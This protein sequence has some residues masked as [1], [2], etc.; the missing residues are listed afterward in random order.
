VVGSDGRGTGFGN[1][2]IGIIQGPDQVNTDLAII[3]R[4]RVA[5]PGDR[6]NIE[7]RA[8]FFNL[9]NHPQFNDPGTGFGTA[10]FGQVLSMAVSPRII[11]FALKF[12]F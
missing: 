7:F 10:A 6:A 11:Q 8:E 12:N 9:F 3:K 4:T 5:W 1:S 2:P